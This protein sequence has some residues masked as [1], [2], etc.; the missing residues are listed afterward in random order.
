MSA[1]T[2][3]RFRRE[4]QIR[5]HN[6]QEILAFAEQLLRTVVAL[7]EGGLL[8]AVN[9]D[10]VLVH[11]AYDV[12]QPLESLVR[13]FGGEESPQRKRDRRLDVRIEVKVHNEVVQ[14]RARIDG[15]TERGSRMSV[16][17]RI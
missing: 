16:A 13:E 6:A 11:R 1:P 7:R 17:Y 5:T 14:R 8:R 12:P 2:H 3:R 15:L 10:G 9:V 4:R